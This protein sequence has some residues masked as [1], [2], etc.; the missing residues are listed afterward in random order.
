MKAQHFFLVGAIGKENQEWVLAPYLPL[1]GRNLLARLP[2]LVQARQKTDHHL[3]GIYILPF[4][5]LKPFSV[6]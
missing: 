1:P 3:R 2:T 6:T 5:S 4:L